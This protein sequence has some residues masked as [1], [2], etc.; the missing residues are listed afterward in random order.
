[1][2]GIMAYHEAS[3]HSPASVRASARRLDWA[4]KPYTYKDYLGDLRAIEIPRPAGSLGLG[5]LDAVAGREGAPAQP[6]DAGL[7]A[8]LLGYG[9]SVIR[10]RQISPTEAWYFRTYASA[11]G[12]YP[13]EIYALTSRLGGVGAG[14][15]HYHP[16]RQVLVQLRDG[17]HRGDLVEAT[18]GEPALAEAPLVLALTGMP[19]RTN[20]KY[21]PRGFRHLYWDAGMISA[22]LLAIA[23]AA[24]LPARVVLGFAD[25]AVEGLLG[26]DG[27]HEVPLCLLAIGA[28]S[29]AP[30]PTG[31]APL[32]LAWRPLSAEEISYPEVLAAQDSGKLQPDRVKVW[33]EIPQA[34][35]P[36]IGFGPGSPDTLERVILRRGSTREFDRVPMPAGALATILDRAT[37]G[38]PTDYAPAG[39]RLIEPHLIA[40]RVEG[41]EAGAYRYDQAFALLGPGDF[42]DAA[43]FLCLEQALG[44][45]AAATHFLMA[46]LPGV[47]SALG[48][49]GYRAAE[50]EAGVTGGRIYL[51]AEAHRIGATGLTFYDDEVTEF[52]A[53][54]GVSP[55]SCM[56]VTA[57]GPATRRLLARA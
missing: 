13:V 15:F 2:P 50:L 43:G 20:W 26:I 57:V 7:L 49:R 45:D 33:R 11:G 41:L 52:F 14:L 39:S 8:R 5:A 1:M 29:P 6:V 32:E 31:A 56:L 30:A 42:S 38:V 16:Q 36:P 24:G 22:N 35:N 19:W 54:P 48:D 21:G 23:A 47:L 18:A 4:N 40:N 34:P 25:T 55:R 17:D 51:A 12:L 3:K 10:K 46:D 37:R 44:R 9:A 27:I 28:G 53:P